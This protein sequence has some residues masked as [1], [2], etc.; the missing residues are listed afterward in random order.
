MAYIQKQFDT[1]QEMMDYLND[2]A[3]SKPLPAK[4][5]GLHGL[6]LIIHDGTADRTVTFSDPTGVGLTPN[7]I[8]DQIYATHANLQTA[9]KLR[10]YRTTVPQRYLLAI[11]TVTY[12]IQD[13]GTANDILGY[14][15]SGDTIV[16]ANAV[17]KS[18]IVM[19]T[20]TESGNK[21]IVVH[22]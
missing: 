5:D 22:E 16:G 14:S 1:A 8:R 2:V 10:N 12:T 6:T 7:Q 11:V 21:Y 17:A 18:N 20:A 3:L 19:M 9:V 4:V 13:S 15:S